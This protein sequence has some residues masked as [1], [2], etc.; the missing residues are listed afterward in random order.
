MKVPLKFEKEELEGLHI[1]SEKEELEGLCL[2]LT[3]V[4]HYVE[5]D[6]IQKLEAES[7]SPESE[8]WSRVVMCTVYSPESEAW[9]GVAE[10]RV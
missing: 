2:L 5:S 7:Q 10:S 6:G 8:A 4:M 9:S 1:K 3:F